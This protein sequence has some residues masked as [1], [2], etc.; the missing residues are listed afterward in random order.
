MIRELSL[1]NYPEFDIDNWANE[2]DRGKDNWFK[3]SKQ[4]CVQTLTD[5]CDDQKIALVS[6]TSKKRSIIE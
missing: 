6:I 4:S 3:A 5:A 2:K 1:R